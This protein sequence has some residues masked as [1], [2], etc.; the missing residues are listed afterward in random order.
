MNLGYRLDPE[1]TSPL[2]ADLL[3]TTHVKDCVPQ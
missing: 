1:T 3:S 2:I